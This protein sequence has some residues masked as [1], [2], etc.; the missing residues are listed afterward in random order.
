MLFRLLAAPQLKNA[1]RAAHAVSLLTPRPVKRAKLTAV[2]S[3]HS[4]GAV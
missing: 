3:T 4:A 1:G 2:N